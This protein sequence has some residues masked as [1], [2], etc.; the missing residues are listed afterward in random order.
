MHCK[1]IIICNKSFLCLW[2]S[3]SLSFF[4]LESSLKFVNSLVML[5]QFEPAW[6]MD[7]VGCLT[8]LS[9][10]Q[11]T[12]HNMRLA[13]QIW[14]RLLGGACQ[15]EW[16]LLLGFNG[17]YECCCFLKLATQVKV[18]HWKEMR[19][20]SSRLL[21]D[22]KLELVVFVFLVVREYA[23]VSWERDSHE[24]P[25]LKSK[26]PDIRLNMIVIIMM[27]IIIIIIIIIIT[28]LV[29]T[30]QQGKRRRRWLINK[31]KGFKCNFLQ[32]KWTFSIS[33]ER[34]NVGSR[35][36]REAN[37]LAKHLLIIILLV[38][39]TCTSTLVGIGFALLC[40]SPD[41]HFHSL[42]ESH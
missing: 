33:W 41:F 23:L 1:L 7:Q 38:S 30:L 31:R 16:A 9:S 39:R 20:A 36:P 37:D 17:F 3:L 6:M 32:K 34:G 26:W 21:F 13:N 25:R 24:I 42:F 22:F 35:W 18:C 10:N 2:V 14:A 5:I 8:L 15:W 27:I 40:H 12:R 29:I 11:E 28:N 4:S 19:W